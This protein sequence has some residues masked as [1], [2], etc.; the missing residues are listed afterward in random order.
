MA[1]VKGK[2]IMLA[3]DLIK[4]KP[5]ARE[6]AIA[7]VNRMTGRDPSAL[8]PEGWYDTSVF[9]AVF[10]AVED[11]HKGIM[12]WAAI[13]VIGQLVYP[14]I[15]ATAGLPD[16]HDDPV[17]FIKFEAEGFLANHRGAEVVPRKFIKA[18]QGHVIVEAPSPGYNCALIEGVFDGILKM[19]HIHD[20]VVKQTKCVKRGD[21]TCE[22]NIKWGA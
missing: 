9:D 1:E 8:D 16:F 7:A 19:C 4:S 20:A 10:S 22:Y 18:E 11:N 5:V 13:V 21:P 6:A 3:C 15:K 14:T 2:F 12:G 17:E